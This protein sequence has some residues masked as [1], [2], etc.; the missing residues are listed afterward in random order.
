MKNLIGIII[1]WV[2]ERQSVFSVCFIGLLTSCMLSRQ[3]VLLLICFQFTVAFI[4]L[5]IFLSVTHVNSPCSNLTCK[6][7]QY[8]VELCHSSSC[9]N[10]QKKRVL[11]IDRAGLDLAWGLL[12]FL[13]CLLLLLL[14]CTERIWCPVTVWTYQFLDVLA[15]CC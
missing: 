11:C 1:D 5:L 9:K 3:F 14:C 6:N 4:F 7:Y 2:L 13:S 8:P 15:F 10:Y 12:L